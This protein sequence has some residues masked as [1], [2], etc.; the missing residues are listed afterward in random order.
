MADRT[1][2]IT[3]AAPGRASCPVI[4]RGPVTVDYLRVHPT[5]SAEQAA[6]LIGVSPASAPWSACAGRM[7]IPRCPQ[8]RA[9]AES[10]FSKWMASND[11]NI[12]GGDWWMA[13]QELER[14]LTFAGYEHDHAVG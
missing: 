7:F 10:G 12:Y 14:A 2:T 4:R 5:V 6:L 8:I 11:N 1:T 3:P 9:E 13:N